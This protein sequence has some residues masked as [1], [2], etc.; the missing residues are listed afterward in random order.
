MWGKPTLSENC[1]IAAE[2]FVEAGSEITI[3]N[4]STRS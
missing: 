2:K 1:K 4:D 3:D